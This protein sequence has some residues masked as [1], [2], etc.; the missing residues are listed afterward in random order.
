M[1]IN[2]YLGEDVPSV[3]RASLHI[4][5]TWTLHNVRFDMPPNNTSANDLVHRSQIDGHAPLRTNM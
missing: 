1:D 4:T 5:A 3:E 2:H